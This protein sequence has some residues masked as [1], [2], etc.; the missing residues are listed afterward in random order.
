MYTIL[1]FPQRN[2]ALI[3]LKPM[4][5]FNSHGGVRTRALKI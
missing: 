3:P 5:D 1:L 2:E 4:I